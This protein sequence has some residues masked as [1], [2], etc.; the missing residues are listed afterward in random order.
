MN[1]PLGIIGV[2]DFCIYLV[3]GIMKRYP[4][5]QILLSPRGRRQSERIHTQFGH[6]IAN[7][8]AE[9]AGQSDMILLATRPAQVE[10]ALVG[11]RFRS[12]Q[13]VISVAAGV[14]VVKLQDLV[15]PANV[16][17]CMP[18]NSAMIG[19]SPVPMFPDDSQA[20][21]ILESFGPVYVL[22]D[23]QQFNCCSVLGA[24]YGWV[25]AL[26][27]ESGEWLQQQGISESTA[28]GLIS[29]MFRATASI[30]QHRTDVSTRAL[31]DELRLPGGLTE[32]GLN[33]FDDSGAIRFWSD[34]M[35]SVLER[36]SKPY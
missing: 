21:P 1:Y 2:G 24:Y 15:S 36:L 31:S 8:N 6:R 33:F 12:S 28:R 35:Q 32:H 9:V 5:M 7:D 23:E 25:L 29:S 22:P 4:D 10:E 18:T 34:V 11:I 17:L 3:E 19:V 30:D 16:V 20:R 13:T 27:A 26:Q 14:S